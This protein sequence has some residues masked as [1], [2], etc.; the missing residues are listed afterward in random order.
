MSSLAYAALWFYVFSVPW[1]SVL[2]I[3]SG[4]NAISKLAGMVAA[5]LA[6]FVA[7][8]RG[9]FRKWHPFHVGALL[10]VVWTGGSQI[11]VGWGQLPLKFWTFPQLCLV[12][13]ITWELAPTRPKVVGLLFAYLFGAYVVALQNIVVSRTHGALMRRIV[14]NGADPNNI[15]MMLALAL[16]IAWHFG[17]TSHRKALRYVCYGYLPVGLVGVV[18]TGSRGGMVTAM[19]AMTIIPLTMNRLTPKKMAVMVALLGVAAVCAVA[20][21]PQQIVDRLSTTG[22]SVEQLSL[23][24]RFSIWR[25]GVQ[26]FAQRP[27]IGYGTGNFKGAVGP[28]GIVQVAHNSYLSVLVEEGLVGFVF[29]GTMMLAAFASVHRLRNPDR[30][31]ARI[32]SLTLAT[33]ML[34]LTW[35]DSKAGWFIMAAL[36]GLSCAPPE[37]IRQ[38]AALRLRRTA[39]A[40][41]RSRA[42][43]RQPATAPTSIVDPGPAV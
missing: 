40:F 5:L 3:G 13:W 9:R 24:G 12:L 2:A 21:V 11:V 30:R 20:F 36:V 29:Y 39:D 41:A 34:P 16:P 4:I 37:P 22:Q 42:A 19:V 23:G 10:F 14:A 1:A 38:A 43:V 31:F 8:L 15:A 25:A 7:L 33:A 18:L 28:Y 17:M 32:L 27:F 6:V 35:E 26:A